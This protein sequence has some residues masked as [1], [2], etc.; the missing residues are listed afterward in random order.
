MQVSTSSHRPPTAK[1][2]GI[3]AKAYAPHYRIKK[4]DADTFL[5]ESS[6]KE[7]SYRLLIATT[8]HVGATALR[9]FAAQEKPAHLSL[10]GDLERAAVDWPFSPKRLIGRPAKPKKPW[11]H[12]KRAIRDVVRGFEDEDRGQLIM[13]CGTGKTLVALWLSEAMDAR[14][15]L[16]LVPSLSL[17]AQ[18]LREWRA[19]ATRPFAALPVCSDE[20][21]RGEDLLATHTSDLPFPVTTDAGEIATF[22]RKRG[23]RVVFSTYHSRQRSRKHMREGG[24][25]ALTSRSR[26][27]RTASRAQLPKTSGQSWTLRRSPLRGGCS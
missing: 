12:V 1:L 26:M 9:T 14:R 6:R 13:A 5:T 15:T 7:F 10:L 16:I 23:P 17:L 21:V 4:S 27:R 24:C 3:Q 2:W 11:P 18:T 8:N 20:T 19:N 22:L 25:Q